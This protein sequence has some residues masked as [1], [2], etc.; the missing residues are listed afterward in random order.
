[1]THEDAG[2]YARKHGPK[3]V[4]NTATRDMLSIRA[5]K[6]KLPCAVAFKV[7]KDLGRSP[8]DVGRTADL[9]ELRLVKC[10]LGLFGYYPQKSILKPL[11]S[12]NTDLEKVILEELKDNR[13]PCKKA[14]E[15]A[16]RF[17]VHKIK[18][19]SACN[20]LEIKIAPCQLGAF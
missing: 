2:H 6:G 15:I 1:M 17:G 5:I 13:L 16:K 10:Q 11:S 12:V 4:V 18:L 7:A 14:W 9:M 8:K 3:A 20:A 19:G